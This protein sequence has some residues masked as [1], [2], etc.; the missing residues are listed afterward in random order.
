MRMRVFA[1]NAACA[2]S[3][4]KTQQM[5]NVFLDA[6]KWKWKSGSGSSSRTLCSSERSS[7]RMGEG[8]ES[9]MLVIY[10]LYTCTMLHVFHYV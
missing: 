7:G 10:I 5:L 6:L 9:K 1:V 2:S 3:K 4:H 8:D